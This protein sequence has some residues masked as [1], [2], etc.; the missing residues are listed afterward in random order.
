[1]NAQADIT[2]P[3]G[4]EFELF[5]D[6]YK[7]VVRSPD[8]IANMKTAFG[9]DAEFF[10]QF[11]I[12]RMVLKST[13]IEWGDE[14]VMN[15]MRRGVIDASTDPKH[16]DKLK[17]LY[18]RHTRIFRD[19]KFDAEY[20]DSIEAVALFFVH[21]DIKTIW[22]AGA[23]RDLTARLIDLVVD[24]SSKNKRMPVGHPIKALTTALSVELNQIQRVFTM[25]ERRV[26][27]TL[28]KDL[29]YGGQLTKLPGGQSP[30][31]ILG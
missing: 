13:N 26:S 8:Q 22:L 20:L 31:D 12:F 4:I 17:S 7:G 1:M 21:R 27:K 24:L 30:A 2:G 23:Y 3:K 25:Y 19:T 28:V 6:S 9:L 29:A 14:I 18:R 16:V 10:A 5:L 15:L 11:E